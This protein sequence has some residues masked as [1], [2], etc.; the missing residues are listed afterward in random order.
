MALG[1]KWDRNQLVG[2]ALQRWVPASGV[3]Q[4]QGEPY[5]NQP[6]VQ[7]QLDIPADPGIDYRGW[8]NPYKS[9]TYVVGLSDT[10]PVLA[11]PGNLR[12]TYLLVQN[13][14][15]GN[16][17]MNFGSDAIVGQCHFFV[18]TQFYEQIGGGAYDYDRRR[19]VPN[20]FVTRD[21]VSA[22][23]D[24]PDTFLIVTEGLWNFQAEEVA[25]AR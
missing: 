15:P 12:R 24:A 6:G 25:G 23:A 21:Y 16:V 20:S 13:I 10:D 4:S 22:I 8:H 2:R 1:P 3:E 11:L 14:G 18:N 17:W 5:F 19:S 9:S 7:R